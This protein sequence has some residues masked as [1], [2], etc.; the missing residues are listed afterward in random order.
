[1][2]G[3]LSSLTLLACL[4]FSACGCEAAEEKATEQKKL[5]A[6]EWC[7]VDDLPKSHCVS[8]DKKVI[9]Q[10]KKDKDYCEEHKNAESLCVKCDPNA[11]AK[12]GAMRPA[13]QEWPMGWKPKG[14]PAK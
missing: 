13:A 12:I 14:A 2:I 5:P 1:M 9:L 3:S 6:A 8:C 10:L 11:P 4:T 7:F